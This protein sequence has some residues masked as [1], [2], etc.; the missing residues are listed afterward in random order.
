MKKLLIFMLVLGMASAASALTVNLSLDG[1]TAAPVSVNVTPGS[2][3]TIYIISDTSGASGDYWT[4]LEWNLP[5]AGSMGVTFGGLPNA[6]I[7]AAAGNTASITDWS[8]AI[9][10]VE[11]NAADS[12]GNV[13]AGTHFKFDM[14]IGGGAATDGSDDFNIWTTKPN[15]GSYPVDDVLT[16]NII[17]EPMTIALLGL[18]GLFLRRRR[19]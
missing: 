7:F 3:T 8:G 9:V 16:I 2:T 4:Y 14:T 6:D 11:F 12:G 17:P 5:S 1:S 13:A 15:D 18:G 10:D 19:A